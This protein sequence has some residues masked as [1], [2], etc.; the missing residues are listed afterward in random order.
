MSSTATGASETPRKY[1]LFI[2]GQWVDAAS[3]QTFTT[4]NPSTGETWA[5][6]AE[7]DKADVDKAV[8]AARKALDGKWGKMAAR[9]RG[10]L[11]YK[12]AQLISENA[13]ELAALES[14]DNG[15]P[16]KES[17]YI[18]LPDVVDHFE[19]FAGWPAKIVGETIPVPGNF[20]NYTLRE[21]VGVCGQIIPWNYPLSMAAW[22]LAPALACGN[23]VVVKPSE[24]TPATAAGCTVVVKPAEQTPVTALE[25]AKLIQ[26]A[27]I[28]DGVVNVVPGYGPTAGAALA[29][30]KG[31][32]KVAFT[33]S[34]E[35]GKIIARACAENLTK[36]SLEL[37]G[38]SPNIVFADANLDQA[39]SGALQAI[40]MNQGQMCT[41]GSRLFLHA[42]IKDEF[43]ARMADKA[44]TIK[45]GDPLDMTTQMG[46]QVSAE[47]LARIKSYVDIA[48]NE[49]AS[50][51]VGGATP[52]LEG[53]LANGY[54]FAPTILDNVTNNM[55]V[56]QE[57]IFGPVASIIT[58]E[59][60][61][62]LVKQANDTLY[63]LGSAIWTQDITRAH[64]I[65]KA[66]KAGVVWINTYNILN[67]A[68]PFGGYK[69]SGYGR[70]MGQHALEMYTQVKSVWVDLSGRPMGWFGR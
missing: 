56:A 53:P 34:T 29:S 39:L 26:Q 18:D 3:G 41:A 55:R 69:Q 20:L 32:D 49:G 8:A 4:P 5:E 33:G 47:Q 59:D 35:V 54:F 21:P 61:A 28:P 12:L 40:F 13:K 58:F 48:A 43:L 37:G 60:E 57:E 30:H 23:T 36:V 11:L 50:V 15:K 24:E 42:A 38:K 22:K 6:F 1:Q 19:Y 2:D 70:E 66:L 65:A 27:G 64:R 31:V 14:Q 25:L 68:S 9:D 67:S 16:L 10:R 51:L 45:V 46:P 44:R 52:T 17:L 63:G 7:A 62:D